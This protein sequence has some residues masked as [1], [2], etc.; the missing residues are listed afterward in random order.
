MGGDD[1]PHW[2]AIDTDVVAR[3]VA[4][5]IGN[6]VILCPPPPHAAIDASDTLNSLM[7]VVMFSLCDTANLLGHLKRS[8]FY[9]NIPYSPY[10]RR[11]ALAK[12]QFCGLQSA[13]EFP[14]RDPPEPSLQLF[15]P[16]SFRDA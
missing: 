15:N 3:G 4:L 1:Y 7:W 16:K 9:G 10:I 8:P 14:L 13:P 2:L 11:E 12:P 6:R 5:N